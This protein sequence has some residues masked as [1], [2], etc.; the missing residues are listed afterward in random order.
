MHILYVGMLLT[1]IVSKYLESTFRKKL[2]RASSYKP[3]W[4]NRNK[5][6]TQQQQ[7]NI[8]MKQ[9]QDLYLQDYMDECYQIEWRCKS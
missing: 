8:S 9:L 5:P 3:S 1:A 7:K 2:L 6:Q 4:K